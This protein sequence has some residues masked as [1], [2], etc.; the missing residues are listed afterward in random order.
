MSKASDDLPEPESPV[1]TVNESRGMS[2]STFFRLCSRAPRI[3]MLRIGYSW[4]VMSGG[5][6]QQMTNIGAGRSCKEERWP[7]A[8]MG[9]AVTLPWP[10]ISNDDILSSFVIICRY[11]AR[12]GEIDAGMAERLLAGKG[13]YR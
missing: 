13:A 10:A 3:S 4:P 6:P 1:I 2:A 7:G 5:Q 12:R 9:A 8:P 11:S